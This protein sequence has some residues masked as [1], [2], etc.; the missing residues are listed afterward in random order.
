MR[1]FGKATFVAA[2]IASLWTIGAS[3]AQAGF[4]ITLGSVT[5]E[6]SDYR[7][8]YSA[9]I[10]GSDEIRTGDFFRI[11]DF[12]GYVPGSI[13]APAGWTASVALTNTTPPPNVFIPLGDDGGVFNLIFT[14]TGA[15][16]ISGATT[17]NG[18][19]ALST[20]GVLG[21][22]KNYVGRNTQATGATAGQPVDAVGDVRVP[23]VP[24]PA[25]VISTALGAVVLGA[26]YGLRRRNSARA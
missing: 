14:Y 22:N 13:T 17:I 21:N 1:R 15:A 23:G 10:T 20:F 24:E 7:W 8:N 26:F 3:Q 4:T 2:V 12:F 19:T 9:A 18:F 5:A 16:T 25:S 11:Y 6:G